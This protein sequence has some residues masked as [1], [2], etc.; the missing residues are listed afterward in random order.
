M[1][2]SR[3]NV[4]P[5]AQT[6]RGKS[7][8]GRPARLSLTKTSSASPRVATRRRAVVDGSS[9]PI[10]NSENNQDSSTANGAEATGIVTETCR[11]GGGPGP[12]RPR[13][14][15]ASGDASSSAAVARGTARR[16]GRT[17]RRR[18]AA[19]RGEAGEG[20]PRH[21]RRR[22]RA[23]VLPLPALPHVL[24][25][26]TSAVVVACS[27][28]FR[29]L[30][31]RAVAFD[32]LVLR[33]DFLSARARLDDARVLR[34]REGREQDAHDDERVVPSRLLRRIGATVA[35][36]YTKAHKRPRRRCS[37]S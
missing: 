25:V 29:R 14:C 20:A 15:T 21:L 33:A 37:N 2:F 8:S 9:S 19:A 18:R 32:R 10:E 23:P 31:A 13:R 12:A 34:H 1:L 5:I 26:V 11:F 3:A 7:P 16:V 24:R 6:T 4:A 35:R 30:V 28:V 27:V 22:R 36:R 17:G